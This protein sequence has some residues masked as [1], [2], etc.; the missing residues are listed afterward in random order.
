[1]RRRPERGHRMWL[2]ELLLC[3]RLGGVQQV[4]IVRAESSALN[5]GCVGPGRQVG[6]RAS[7]SITSS[8][9]LF[10]R[11]L[12]QLPISTPVACRISGDGAARHLTSGHVASE[13]SIS[14]RI[15]TD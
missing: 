5:D 9:S 13:L 14:R 15:R 2:R 6:R 10:A 11:I 1:M 3:G 8:V 7:Y 4:V 12:Y